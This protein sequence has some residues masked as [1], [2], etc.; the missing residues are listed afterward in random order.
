MKNILGK[1]LAIVLLSGVCYG[2]DYSDAGIAYDKKDYQK[3]FN[4]YNKSCDSGDL[5]GCAMVGAIYE[6]GIVVTRNYYKALEYYDKACG[7]GG[8]W[9]CERLP[10]LKE[11]MPVC[12][13][14]EIS[15]TNDKRYFEV[16][17]TAD[18][19]FP[20]IVADSKTIK[21]DKKS[22]IIKIW[23]TWIASDSE[24]QNKISTL[25]QYNN[26]DNFGYDKGLDTINYGSMKSKTDKYSRYN[27]N[28]SV[29]TSSN[30]S[31]EWDDI[32][33][34][35]VMEVIT[36]SIVKKYNLK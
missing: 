29:I 31:S 16:A 17:S 3:A 33:P 11:K 34:G 35:S 27:C 14:S 9:S 15:F 2:D 32:V 13:E 22:K 1:A 25:G 19:S 7:M 6:D 23:T 36:N 26:Y 30:N 4:L 18:N 8:N 20:L 12:A 28:G 10:I 5:G 21:I 24:R